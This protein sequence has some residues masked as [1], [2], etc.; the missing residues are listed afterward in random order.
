MRTIRPALVI[1]GA[2]T[3]LVLATVVGS[4]AWAATASTC[5]IAPV[6]DPTNTTTVT[7]TTIDGTPGPDLIVCAFGVHQGTTV[8][9]EGGDDVITVTL[10]PTA[11]ADVQG[12]NHGTLHGGPGNDTITSTDLRARS[13]ASGNAGFMFGDEG[14]D[15]LTAE[16]PF[17]TGNNGSMEGGADNDV[18]SATGLIA[19]NAF[20]AQIDGDDEGGGGDDTVLAVGAHPSTGVGNAG[21]IRTDEGNDLVTIEGGAVGNDSQVDLGDG[22]DILDVTALSP[23]GIGNHGEINSGAGDDTITTDAPSRGNAGL[24]FGQ[25]GEDTILAAGV[26]ANS[27]TID[28]G[29]DEDTCVLVGL[30]TGTVSN[31]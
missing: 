19:G 31:C 18:V 10:D 28:G 24:L 9:G 8:N 5:T 26:I 17:G 21:S 14:D 1:C 12:A 23:L 3:A 13:N 30:N 29:P 6:T 22:H 15:T 11:A 2:T 4:P 20:D 27:E 25:A 7:S 16:S